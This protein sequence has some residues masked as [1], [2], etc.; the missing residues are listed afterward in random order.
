MLPLEVFTAGLQSL[1]SWLMSVLA[2]LAVLVSVVVCLLFVEM[3]VGRQAVARAYT[4]KINSTG[5]LRERS[6]R[7]SA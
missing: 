1:S 5:S 4:V 6:D 3:I 2:V 7:H